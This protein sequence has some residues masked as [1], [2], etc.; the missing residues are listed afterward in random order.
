MQGDQDVVSSQRDCFLNAGILIASPVEENCNAEFHQV[1]PCLQDNPEEK[2]CL[3]ELE[4]DIV[5]LENEVES[6]FMTLIQSRVFLLN[7]LSL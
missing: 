4:L 3:Q 5:D 1:V 2:S 6:L 7:T